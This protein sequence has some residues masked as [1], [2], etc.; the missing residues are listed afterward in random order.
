MWVVEIELEHDEVAVEVLGFWNWSWIEGSV[1]ALFSSVQ[2]QWAG[3]GS[4]VAQR[5]VKTEKKVIEN[6]S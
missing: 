6:G 5:I 1:V 3:Q 2:A 4:M